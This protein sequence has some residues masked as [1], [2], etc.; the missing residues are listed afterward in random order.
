MTGPDIAVTATDPAAT[1][2]PYT[3]PDWDWLTAFG[4]DADR[5]FR[6]HGIGANGQ[7]WCASD[8]AHEGFRFSDFYDVGQLVAWLHEHWHCIGDVR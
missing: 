7:M 6:F 4:I 2:G 5:R 3:G 8:D 1:V